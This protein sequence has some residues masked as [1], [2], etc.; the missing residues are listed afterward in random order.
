VLLKKEETMR[1]IGGRR[2]GASVIF[3]GCLLVFCLRSGAQDFQP[4]P[5]EEMK[6]SEVPGYPGAPA[7][8]LYHEEMDDDSQHRVYGQ[9]SKS[10]YM[11]IKVLTEAGRDQANV[12]LPY[13]RQSFK[14]DGIKG[15]TVHADGSIVIFAGKPFDKSVVKGKNLHYNVKAFTLPDVQVGSIIEYSYSLSYNT[16]LEPRWTLQGEL[17]Q[18][19]VSY[20]FKPFSGTLVDPR[21]GVRLKG[22]KWTWFTPKGTGVAYRDGAFVYEAENVPPFVEE[23]H[24]PQPS[25]LKY[26]IQF[27]YDLN[28]SMEQFWAD[29]GKYWTKDLD[30]FLDEKG[31]LS[32]ELGRIVSPND[33]EEQK[34]RKIYA[35]VGGYKN[36]TYAPERTQQE[37][38]TIGI[39]GKY[40]VDKVIRARTGDREDLTRLFIGLVREA[41]IPA[42]A[43]RVTAR[44]DSYFIPQNLSWSQLDTEIAIVRINDK[45]VFLDPGTRFC[46][47]GLMHW[48]LTSAKGVRQIATGATEIA[49]APDPS[50]LNAT[51]AR[52]AHLQLTEDGSIEGTVEISFLGQEALLR[53]VEGAQTDDEGRTK[54]LEDEIK[55]WLPD[56]AEVKLS[57]KP[58]W[59]DAD[60]ALTAVLKIKSP[61]ATNAGRRILVPLNIFHFNRP[62]TF[63]DATRKY[64][65]HFDYPYGTADEIHMKLPANL[66]VESVPSKYEV[67]LGYAFYG[68]QYQYAGRELTTLRRVV[69]GST[70]IPVEKYPEI[71]GFCEKMKAGD[72]QQVVLNSGV[73]IVR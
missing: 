55:S 53:R 12:E 11:R 28:R 30:R 24:M 58:S 2:L 66:S 20:R 44:D 6:I 13:N 22:V 38:K 5:A 57:N 35:Y 73:H 32:D 37:M 16:F 14:L 61:L 26:S 41:G 3:A 70:L 36:L 56:T 29:E 71:K 18:R 23:P 52:L 31:A 40:K 67:K 60:Q 49:Q 43:M 21:S 69:F 64:A 39:A 48:T 33:S 1:G 19:R 63:T 46:P 50:Y 17:F 59:G 65:V 10:V 68:S 54:L 47:F 15:R 45:E 51:I 62:A 9:R 27:Y 72:D 42:Y 25:L 34:V 8:V 4:I 7:M